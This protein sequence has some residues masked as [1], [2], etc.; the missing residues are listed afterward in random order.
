MMRIL[1]QRRSRR[2]LTAAGVLVA[3]L[4][5]G[6]VTAAVWPRHP[7]DTG[8]SAA[9]RAA[10]RSTAGSS[11]AGTGRRP[12]SGSVTGSPT[13]GPRPPLRRPRP[14]AAPWLAPPATRSATCRGQ[15]P[16]VLPGLLL[17]VDKF[18]NRLIIVDPQGRVRW[19]FPRPGDLAPARR[20]GSPTT[21]SSARTAAR[22]SPP[23][24]TRQ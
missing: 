21:P 24:R 17:I 4:V 13:A 16:V 18:N 7:G 5:L 10:P 12:A 19:V 3:A 14:A 9:G 22:S 23:R 20:S 15:R 11:A 2:L 1:P 8:A 6:L